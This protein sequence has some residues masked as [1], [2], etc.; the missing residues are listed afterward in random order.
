MGVAVTPDG[1]RVYGAVSFPNEGTDCVIVVIATDSNEVI[2]TIKLHDDYLGLEGV[3]ITPD[4]TKVYVV[5]SRGMVHVIATDSNKVIATIPMKDGPHRIAI[6]PDS[7]KAYVTHVWRKIVSVIATDSNKVTNII[8]VEGCSREI[9]IAPDGARAYVTLF[10]DHTVA[11]IDTNS[12]VVIDPIKEK[13]EKKGRDYG[14]GYKGV[15]ITHDGKQVYMT[16]MHGTV[17]V[18]DTASRAVIGTT[19]VRMPCGVVAIRQLTW[20]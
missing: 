5:D 4:G 14:D 7:T 17:S 15:A 19:E 2:A 8:P 11:V 3:A 20:Q 12:N 10:E 18:V 6:T 16:D 13:E 1:T 9:V